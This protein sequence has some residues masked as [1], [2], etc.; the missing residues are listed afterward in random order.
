MLII[1]SAALIGNNAYAAAAV[2]CTDTSTCDQETFT[3]VAPDALIVLDLSVNMTKNSAGG[4]NTWG[5][6]EAC[7]ATATAAAACSPG[8]A[9]TT[10][11]NYGFSNNTS[12]DT[13]YKGT[14]GCNIDCSRLGIAK[15]AIFDILDDDNNGTIDNQDASSLGIRFGLLRFKGGDDYAGS[16]AT[17]NVQL[18]KAIGTSYQNIY[19]GAAASNGSCLQTDT[20]SS[21]ECIA[22]ETASYGA[23]LVRS[24]QEAKL[25]LD[26]HKAADNTAGDCRQKFVILV[27]TS[28]DDCFEETSCSSTDPAVCPYG[29]SCVGEC[30]NGNNT[31]GSA[32]R[33][34]Q[35]VV[36]AKAL[37]TAGY[38]VYAVGFGEAMP[39]YLK[40]T[41]NWVARYGGTDN[42][43]ITNS[44]NPDAYNP[45]NSPANRD[46]AGVCGGSTVLNWH[47]KTNDPG[48]GVSSPAAGATSYPLSGYA[49]LAGNAADL[50]YYLKSAIYT[51]K[52]QSYSFT[53]VS[54]QT[55]RTMDENYIYEASFSPLAT[56]AGTMNDPFWLGHLKRYSIN[57]DGSLPASA[58]WDA[59]QILKG[60]NTAR[61]IYTYKG[62]S[63][64]AFNTT[65][66]APADLNVAD[67]A[68]RDGIV[69]F[70][71]NGDQ[72]YNPGTTDGAA[73]YGW[74]LGDIFHSSPI[75]IGTPSPYFSDIVDQGSTKAYNTYRED[76]ERTSANGKRLI[77]A[78]ANDGQF[79]VFRTGNLADGGGTELWSFIPPNLL[80]RLKGLYHTT[81]T[82]GGMHPTKTSSAIHQYFVDGPTTASDI[83][84]GSGTGTTKLASEWKAYAIISEGRG[85]ASTLWCSSSSC[86][87]GCTSTPGISGATVANPHYCGYYAFDLTDTT[88]TP[89]FKWH[90]GGTGG[91]TAAQASYL[92]EPWSKITIGRVKIAG[93]ERW[94]GFASAGYSGTDC[95]N[96]TAA[97]CDKRGKGFYVIDML[98]GNVL[99]TY[100]YGT[101]SNMAYSLLAQPASVDYDDDGFIET[102]YVPD[103]G[104]N[105]WRFK[106]CT[107]T[108]T[109][110][111][112]ISDW[113][114]GLFFEA[115][116]GEIRPS[117]SKVTVAKSSSGDKWVF[118]GTGDVND[119]TGSSA[120]ERMYGAKD[121]DRTTKHRGNELSNYTSDSNCGDT[122]EGWYINM[123][124]SGQKILADPTVYADVVYFTLYKPGNVNDACDKSGGAYLFAVNFAT[125]CGE[126]GDGARSVYVGQGIASA[127]VVSEN[128]Y[129]GTNIY[130]T[131]SEGSQINPEQPPDPFANKANMQYWHDMRVR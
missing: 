55:V 12:G 80:T 17:G 47:T 118:W 52:E 98:N 22:N 60:R 68:T 41:L 53:R 59:G 69:N 129:G 30:D 107:K 34:R 37:N 83:W 111:C 50:S 93:N 33:R 46:I 88:G 16:Y 123:S 128:P 56:S 25:Y 121:N 9:D 120:Q 8:I 44:G 115:Q 43:M 104:G 92:G 97:K 84:I 122:S 82:I 101:N 40:N 90:F 78:G 64:I 21:G 48:Y 3:S 114:G 24:L 89:Q 2:D 112:G 23:A 119:P 96:S 116:S 124:G 35:I 131:T 15:R 18:I 1:L 32:D 27:T 99:W 36:A 130:V 79:H 76:N 65:N 11:P 71:H 127:P 74:K 39:D 81:T 4:T 75:S 26:A 58:D 100:N 73:K 87:S 106:M 72:A 49:F 110:S 62:G 7:T 70:I 108:D 105:I 103:L 10:D 51:I 67:T 6:T 95:K 42:P 28:S 5:S 57:V 31:N 38:Q 54:V 117:Y 109:S 61:T 13:N 63:L 66:I 29:A 85:A 125:A 77:V 19:C 102:V 45:A 113:T 14:T 20:C 126:Y 86:D 94:V 91:L